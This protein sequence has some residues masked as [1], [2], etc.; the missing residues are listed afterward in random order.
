MM[1]QGAVALQESTGKN[2]LPER[3]EV[4]KNSKALCCKVPDLGLLDGFST[5]TV[6]DFVA[7]DLVFLMGTVLFFLFS[8]S[9]AVETEQVWPLPQVTTRACSQVSAGQRTPEPPCWCLYGEPGSGDTGC[10][11]NSSPPHGLT[12]SASASE[13]PSHSH[14]LWL[15]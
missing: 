2:P 6:V 13:K 9:T 14:P 15:D 8:G 4:A 11:G 1:K 3:V 10:C 7:L 12:S 5:A